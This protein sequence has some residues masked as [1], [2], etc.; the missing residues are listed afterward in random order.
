MSV[1][2]SLAPAGTVMGLAL[3]RL[4]PVVLAEPQVSARALSEWS[5]THRSSSGAIGQ[6]SGRLEDWPRL[7]G[8]HSAGVSS[9]DIMVATLS[10]RATWDAC[11]KSRRTGQE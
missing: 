10:Y 7:V 5:L 4:Y 9:G 6:L 11:T 2:E 8:P 1:D 3:Y